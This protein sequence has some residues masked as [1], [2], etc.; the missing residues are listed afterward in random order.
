MWVKICNLITVAIVIDNVS[1][2]LI[3]IAVHSP[4]HW[5]IL[6]SFTLHHLHT[7]QWLFCLQWETPKAGTIT[8]NINLKSHLPA[9]SVWLLV[10]EFVHGALVK[11]PHS[12]RKHRVLS[13]SVCSKSA[14]VNVLNTG[15]WADQKTS[16]QVVGMLQSHL[17]LGQIQGWNHSNF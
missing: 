4:L 14:K 8:T 13:C 11:V 15:G 9:P 7:C 12:Q 5:L 10:L 6:I 2:K 1:D 16:N 3:Y 17:Q